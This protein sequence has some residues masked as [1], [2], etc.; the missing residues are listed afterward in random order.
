ML[1]GSFNLYEKQVASLLLALC[2]QSKEV[3]LA[4]GLHV[5]LSL[6]ATE[7]LKAKTETLK[8]TPEKAGA[9]AGKET[10]LRS[11]SGSQQD[12]RSKS[13]RMDIP[14]RHSSDHT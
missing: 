13:S 1:N 12:S 5:V 6:Y 11:D 14:P 10:I 2:E 9:G 3:T 7:S 4:T 8:V